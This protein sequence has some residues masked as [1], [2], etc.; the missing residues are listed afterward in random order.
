M[1]VFRISQVF[2][3]GF[4]SESLSGLADLHYYANESVRCIRKIIKAFCV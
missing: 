4:T 1:G 2:K 3:S